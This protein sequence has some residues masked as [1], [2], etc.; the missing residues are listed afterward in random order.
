MIYYNKSI[1]DNKNVSIKFVD[2]NTAGN[3]E[4][5]ELTVEL[6]EMPLKENGKLNTAKLDELS[7]DIY[8]DKALI[9]SCFEGKEY[10]VT[11]KQLPEA[12]EYTHISDIIPESKKNSVSLQTVNNKECDK[13]TKCG[14]IAEVYGGDIK[15]TSYKGKVIADIILETV[16]KYPDEGIYY[17]DSMGFKEF[18]TYSQTD[19]MAKKLVTG[20]AKAGFKAKD[21]AIFQ[22]SSS[23]EYVELFWA[24]MYSG[25]IPCP[26]DVLTDYNVDSAKCST[27]T[28]IWNVMGKPCIILSADE[29]EMMTE[30]STEMGIPK[31]KL[32]CIDTLADNAPVTELT[33]P[34]PEDDAIIFFTSGSSGLPKGVVQKQKAVVS[35]QYGLIQAHD[36]KK[37][38]GLNWMPLEH[39]GGIIM[40]H[41]RSVSLGSSQLQVNTEY[42]LTDPLRWLDLIDK[43]RVSYSWAPHFAFVLV[44]EAAEKAT[45]R[46]WDLSCVNVLQN[47]GEMI[48]AKTARHFLDVLKKYG[49][50]DNVIVP[51]WGM[52]ETCS[53]TVFSETFDSE[54]KGGTQ[55]YSFDNASGD[56]TFYDEENS[57]ATVVT[58]IGRPIPG[59]TIRIAN[60][61]NETVTEDVIGRF[62]IKG[63]PITLGY[64]N[65]PEENQKAF[66][67]D[68][69]FITGDLGFIHNGKMSLTGREKNVIIINGVNYNNVEIESLIE[70]VEDVKTSFTA[71]T[72]IYNEKIGTDQIA[73][74]YVPDECA[75]NEFKVRK[76][77]EKKVAD[78]LRLHI[79][80]VIPLKEEEIPKTN[81][82]KIQ[83]KQLTNR[84]LSGEYDEMLKKAD[85]YLKNENVIPSWLY[86][87]E[88]IKKELDTESNN[89]DKKDILVISGMNGHTDLLIASLRNNDNNIRIVSFE[90]NSKAEYIDALDKDSVKAFFT[91]PENNNFDKIVYCPSIIDNKL[92]FEASSEILQK[93]FAGLVNISGLIEDDIIKCKELYVITNELLPVNGSVNTYLAGLMPGFCKCLKC[94]KEDVSVSL[95]DIDDIS[96]SSCAAE[97]EATS[98]PS[99]VA[100]RNGIRYIMKLKEQDISKVLNKKAFKDNSLY[101]VTGG[102]SGVGFEMCKYLISHYDSSLIIV[103]RSDLKNDNEKNANYELLKQNGNYVYYCQCSADDEK[104]IEAAISAAENATSLKLNKIIHSAGICD[105]NAH[106]TTPERFLI[107]NM[108]YKGY[109]S[110]FRAKVLGSVA[111]GRIAERRKTSVCFFSST[112]AFLGSSSFSAYAAANSFVEY[113]GRYLR[114]CKNVDAQVLSFSAWTNIGINKNN[115][116]GSVGERKGFCNMALMQGIASV[117]CAVR[118]DAPS[119]YIGL[120]NS[121]S[122]TIEYTNSFNDNNIIANINISDSERGIAIG[123]INTHFPIKMNYIT[124][125]ASEEELQKD[126]K[127]RK[128]AEIWH[129][130]IGDI[131]IDGNSDFFES[132][133]KS[134]HAARLSG[135]IS[136]QFNINF[137]L[138]IIMT[139]SKFIEM[140]NAIKKLS[141]KK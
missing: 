2:L 50:K 52:C 116:F 118:T 140:L 68:G 25:V 107:K 54:N 12:R 111:L 66:T 86:E 11:F 132:G 44:G 24:C 120:N 37:D 13:K 115:K 122:E 137:S 20:L 5:D 102:L 117:E 130:V 70:E 84:L 57:V 78:S 82:G 31:E 100:Y 69:W 73:V 36:F 48:N 103:G 21:K 27:F 8:K 101:L 71:V 16:A 110:L 88:W 62:L 65:N 131:S 22:I 10:S 133:G 46:K 34:D 135:L 121:G 42:I 129:Q 33:L 72:A 61:N 1:T 67:E 96:Y 106:M 53:G 60:N 17:Y 58:E 127:A 119:V 97:I 15:D 136:N 35:Q 7:E 47:G 32:F 14:T 18:C 95:I 59:I 4:N 93:A 6:L 141:V 28:Q 63:D 99:E 45:D 81:L 19:E 41:L 105:F 90:K 92:D 40:A 139:Q 138:K 75:D 55:I 23:K 51:A 49:M 134:V 89:S 30:H 43:Y 123:K 83:R 113:Y 112:N 56:V 91:K 128:L 108:D 85:I 114:D 79:D 104:S 38:I 76:K 98:A 64:Y 80:Y 29:Y 87:T 77:I 3:K 39:P 124:A 26:M 9:D 125:G 94:E 126:E 109:D 74:F